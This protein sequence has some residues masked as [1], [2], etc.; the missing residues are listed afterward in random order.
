[1]TMIEGYPMLLDRP[2]DSAAIVETAE[3]LGREVL[4]PRAAMTDAG[5]GPPRENFAALA[6]AGLMGLSIP[7]QYS[8]LDA[9]PLA[10]LIVLET[11]SRFCAATAFLYTQH[12]GTCGSIAAGGSA[13]A[14]QILPGLAAGE[15]VVG[16]GASQLRHAGP[17]P[18][19]ARR[20]A[21]GFVID[22]TVP[23]ASGY[24]LMTHL[25]LGAMDEQDLP[26][27]FW[28]PFAPAQGISF[29]AVQDTVVMRSASTVPVR[30]EG[31]FVPEEALVGD[32]REGYWRA[33][34]GGAL[35]NPVAFLLGIGSG[36]LDGLR[37]TA[38]RDDG[39]GQRARI[40]ALEGDLA[41]L[42]TRFYSLTSRFIE[43]DRGEATLD[44]LLET[45]VAVSA[46]VLR[47]AQIAIVAAG[48]R[49][50]LRGNPAQ[51]RLREASF[52]L[53]ATVNR[54]AREALIQG[55]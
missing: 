32:D 8:G 36:C 20:T 31:L 42:Q 54:S 12:M 44:A 15:L 11:L 23:W 49:A 1:M 33:R 28:V 41:A 52:F 2:A 4:A 43:G 37:A 5:E 50:H 9:D 14:P 29:G 35:S 27:F 25:V 17:P 40:A 16:I 3:N 18:L 53:T 55:L 30:C 38:A 21:G 10:R 48:G 26:L 13:L 19:R 7:A 22:G 51:R 46:L 45:R 39:P 47:L 34:H 6:Q 24:G